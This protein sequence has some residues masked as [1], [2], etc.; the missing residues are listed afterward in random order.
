[1]VKT[2]ILVSGGGANLQAIIDSHLFGEIPNCELCAVISSNTDAYALVRAKS[3]GIEDVVVNRAVFANEKSFMKAIFEKLRDLDIELVVLAGFEHI[4]DKK[5]VDYY[6]NR[7]IAIYPSLLPAFLSDKKEE[8]L[9]HEMALEYG[10]KVS[11]ATAYFATERVGSGAVILQQSVEISQ[12]DTAE[13]LQRKIMEDAEWSILPRAMAL[14]CSGLLEV[15][16]NRV[17]I[18]SG[19][20]T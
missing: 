2:A 19:E 1:M 10:A 3:A 9:V 6:K 11:G 16:G 7:I 8:I 15:E 17:S 12:S 14:Y 20:A 13:T 4:L 18:K 5:T